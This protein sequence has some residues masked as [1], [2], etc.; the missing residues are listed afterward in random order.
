MIL[1][2]LYLI[3]FATLVRAL[4]KIKRRKR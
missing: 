3:A 4:M 2:L 1:A